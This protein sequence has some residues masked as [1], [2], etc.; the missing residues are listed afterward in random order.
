MTRYCAE[1]IFPFT[2]RQSG[3]TAPFP[4][5]ARL[6]VTEDDDGNVWVIHDG[7]EDAASDIAVGVSTSPPT[8]AAKAARTAAAAEVT[9]SPGKPLPTKVAGGEAVKAREL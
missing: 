3:H 2:L 5:G 9:P 1:V 6:S 7:V 8:K 4:S